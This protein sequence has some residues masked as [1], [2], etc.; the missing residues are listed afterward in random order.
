[1]KHV[2]QATA[3]MADFKVNGQA[4]GVVRELIKQSPLEKTC[5][6][7][8]GFQE[9]FTGREQTSSTSRVVR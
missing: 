9:R 3:Q 2:L 1:M 7:A 4:D 8:K 6:I 5:V